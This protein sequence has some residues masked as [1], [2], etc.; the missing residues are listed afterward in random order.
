[1]GAE[2]KLYLCEKPSQGE[3]VAKF[4][5]MSPVHKKQ[6][7]Y[8]NGDVTVTWA[9]G[10]LFKL[11]PPEYYT[12]EL[13]KKWDFTKLPVLPEEYKYTLDVK[14]K[15]QWRVIKNLLKK[16]GE[17]YI[18]TDPDPE[19]ECIARNILK[20]AAYKGDVFRILYGSTDKKTLTKAFANP[21]P[22]GET[23]WMY[24]SAQARAMADW[25]VGMNL[26]MAMTLVVQKLESSSGYKKA[27][28]IGRVKT[29][30]AMLVYLRE[31]AIKNFKPVKY[32][33]VE[34]DVYTQ[35]NDQFTVS[36]E[37]PEK[38]LVDGRLLECGYAEKAI[39]YIKAQK[40]G[41]IDSLTKEVKSKQP[42]LPF[43]L[44]SLQSACEKFNI[45]PDET[46]EIA[47]S[48]YDK[49][50]SA[51]TYPR[52]DTPY[53]TSGLAEDIAETVTHLVKLEAFSKI[54]DKLDLKRRT[55]AWNDKKVKVHYGI[56]PTVTA[57][58]FARLTDKQKAVYLMVAKRYLVQFLPDYEYESTEVV[59]KFGNLSCKATCN[60][61]KYLGWRSFEESEEGSESQELPVVNR[62][63]K[64]G[65]K[66]A[67]IIEKTTRK[68][69]RYTQSSLAKA[70]VNISSDVSDDG[71]RKLLSDKDGIGTVAT[72]PSI[73][74]DL[75][76]SGL[77]NEKN[78]QLQPSRWFEKYMT[79]IPKQIQEPANSA[80]WE[81]GF[82]A[83]KEGHITTDKF[84]EFQA[85]FVRGAV[86][87]L[88]QIFSEI[89]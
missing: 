83:I 14:D 47:Q 69:P 36:W 16:A 2:M 11:Q 41:L 66:D 5:G 38:V 70:M 27:F 26:T 80:L 55:K 3:D 31:Q 88:Y 84:V 65:I 44:T 89:K 50:N 20:F 28:P 30:A 1:M 58:N 13:K 67:R 85:K 42:P 73:I 6:G 12:P 46:L 68:P 64:V 32:Y 29:P 62:G 79:H 34:V 76:K 82:Q 61:P 45:N 54:A 81:R 60:I 52:T 18:A 37:I 24:H 22:S 40:V 39:D 86:S 15:A 4:L 10:H 48:L 19:G 71:L 21:L 9:R 74:K 35:S 53:L 59:V 72:R 63:L 51:T 25:V 23:E 77:L 17:V 43:E 75:I 57:L 56:I 78:R 7:Y 8:Q 87:E 49:P 33:E